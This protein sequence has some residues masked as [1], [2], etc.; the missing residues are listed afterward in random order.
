MENGDGRDCVYLFGGFVDRI[1]ARGYA[2]EILGEFFCALG[3]YLHFGIHFF[4]V[5]WRLDVA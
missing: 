4:V 5:R 1:Y 2:G 3:I